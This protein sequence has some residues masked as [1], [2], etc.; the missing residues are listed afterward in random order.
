[1]S[2]YRQI[3]AAVN[4]INYK[5]R[6]KSGLWDLS[7]AAHQ[8]DTADVIY[9]A[10]CK[11]AYHFSD[12]THTALSQN[13]KTRRVARYDK[14]LG[15]ENVLCQCVKQILDKN[16]KVKYPNRNDI[17]HDLFS[18]VRAIHKMS[19]FTIVRIDFKD[20][21]NT[22]SAA[23]V[24]HKYLK[25]GIRDREE[26][27]LAEK[28][29]SATGMTYAGLAASNSIAEIIAEIFDEEVKNVFFGDGLIFYERYVDDAI[30]LF[31]R[32]LT[33]RDIKSKINGIIEKVYRG[34]CPANVQKCRT[35]LN[36]SKFRCLSKREIIGASGIKYVDFLGYEFGFFK[37]GDGVS[38]Q[39]G[40]TK[41]KQCKYEG[42]LKKI[43]GE[44]G[45]SSKTETDGELLRQRIKAF[46]SR[47][48]YRGR[49]FH[50]DTWKAKGFITNYGELRYLLNTGD[51]DPGT[52]TFL[53]NAVE[54]AFQ[55]CGVPKPYYLSHG[56]T[57]LDGMT[58]NR[59]LILVEGIGYDYRSLRKLC[60][61]A[62]I[63]S[64]SKPTYDAL[65]R[66]YLIKMLVGY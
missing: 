12:L 56:Y 15:V 43:I 11:G 48:V 38:V 29:A 54:D 44:Y 1:M 33:D 55:A 16:F 2:I 61:K 62:G 9:D 52:K 35:K 40:I 65:V 25:N 42:R 57:L 26:A 17:T 3:Q 58:K 30:L 59:S 50:S 41:E 21:F 28:Y 5:Q 19:H 24:F 31:N 36:G 4:R 51:I 27:D 23:Y 7:A 66:E 63:I 6:K 64:G 39:Y 32:D 14:P 45:K 47:T 60:A 34:E 46:I 22:V 18:Y 49:Y 8:P 20:Y 37:K 53:A 13:G 10:Y